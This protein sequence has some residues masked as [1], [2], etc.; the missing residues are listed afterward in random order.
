[1][2]GEEEEQIL[3]VAHHDS[4]RQIVVFAMERHEKSRGDLH[5]TQQFFAHNGPLTVSEPENHA[6]L[7]RIGLFIMPIMVQIATY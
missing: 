2:T 7:E 6:R 3:T 4:V 5:T 1:M